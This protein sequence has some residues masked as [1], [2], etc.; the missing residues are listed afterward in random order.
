MMSCPTSTVNRGPHDTRWFE[1]GAGRAQRP[2]LGTK[3]GTS[4]AMRCGIIL[5]LT[6]STVLAASAA[7]AHDGAATQRVAYAASDGR[8]ATAFEQWTTPIDPVVEEPIR[9]LRRDASLLLSGVATPSCGSVGTLTLG[10]LVLLRT[11]CGL[12]S[13]TNVH[14]GGRK[15]DD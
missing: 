11:V 7:G 5:V 15:A 14:R 6:F 12:R 8:E 9:R 2:E 13:H 10:S 4:M 1:A 3:R